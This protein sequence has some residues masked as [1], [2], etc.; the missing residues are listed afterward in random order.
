MKRKLHILLMAML[1][2][3]LNSNLFAQDSIPCLFDTLLQ[4]QKAE[5]PKLQK[6]LNAMD[7]GVRYFREDNPNLNFYPKP[8]PAPPCDMC[9]SIDPSCFKNKYA[10]PV[11][12]HIVHLSSD[13]LGQNSNI[14]D[15]QVYDAIATLN[16]KFAGYNVTDSIA[17]NTGIQFYLAPLGANSNGIFRYASNM[18]NHIGHKDSIAKLLNL[19]DSQYRYGNYIN[20]F[21]VNEI[22]VPAAAGYA[23]MPNTG[24]NQLITMARK[25]FGD[26]GNCAGCDLV[27]STNGKA[28]AHEF[29]HYLGLYHTFHKGCSGMNSSDC[30]TEGDECCDTPPV[31]ASNSGCPGTPPNSCTETPIDLPDQIESFMDYASDACARWFTRN[32]ADNPLSKLPNKN[33][34]S[35]F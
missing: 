10:L 17:V 34:F 4:Q 27:S 12:V 23:S 8:Q 6:K 25:Y 35:L 7:Y 30:D 22:N 31:A 24:F 19:I 13:T 9:M 20:V 26:F 1:L 11:L 21:V 33:M 16:K 15:G 29:G 3:L 2:P 14:P 5:D 32:Q 18:S 28:L